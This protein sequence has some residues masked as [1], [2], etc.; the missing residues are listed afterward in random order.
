M[1]KERRTAA[2]AL[3]LSPQIEDFISK[4]I[5]SSIQSEKQSPR[6]EEKVEKTSPV[7]LVDSDPADTEKEPIERE[8]HETMGSSPKRKQPSVAVER[9]ETKQPVGYANADEMQRLLSKATVQKTVRFQPRLI[10]Q[11]EAII[12]NQ[13]ARGEAPMSFQQIQNDALKLWL[14][15]F[16][17]NFDRP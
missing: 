3:A 11:M 10:A 9:K 12:R 16:E 7:R 6:V 5:S 14:A 2:D 8:V 4:G 17:T 13:E 15:K 1:V